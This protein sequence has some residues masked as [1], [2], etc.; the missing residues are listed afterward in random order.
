MSNIRLF[1]NLLIH[2]P[3]TCFCLI[4]STWMYSYVGIKQVTFGGSEF[5]GW[6]ENLKSEDVGYSVHR[7]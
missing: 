1:L 6:E 2:L 7:I 4:N 5:E 3:I